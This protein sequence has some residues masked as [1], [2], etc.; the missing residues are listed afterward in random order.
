LWIVIQRLA[1]LLKDKATAK[2][3]A[4]AAKSQAQSASRT[5]ELLIDQNKENEE[6]G[7][8]QKICFFA[9]RFSRRINWSNP[10]G[11]NRL[12]DA[13]RSDFSENKVDN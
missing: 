6:K 5:A 4:S 11:D 9:S 10:S 3:E 8:K 12:S 2:A 1:S 7:K 13:K